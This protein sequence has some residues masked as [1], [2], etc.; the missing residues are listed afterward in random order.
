MREL[1]RN[2]PK[3]QLNMLTH[4]LRNSRKEDR[5]EKFIF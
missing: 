3:M 2:K 5:D 1:L 4:L